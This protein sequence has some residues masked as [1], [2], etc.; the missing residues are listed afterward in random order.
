MLGTHLER[1]EALIS[2]CTFRRSSAVAQNVDLASILP[3]AQR[4]DD[5]FRDNIQLSVVGQQ[6]YAEIFVA[7]AAEAA[8]RHQ[9]CS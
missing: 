2:K 5:L 1:R 9:G 6:R 3:N 8:T 4:V 7:I